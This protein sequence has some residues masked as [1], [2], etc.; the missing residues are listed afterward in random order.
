[1]WPA[2]T[3]I[4][5]LWSS[6]QSKN[7]T[8]N[9]PTEET[10]PEDL[11]PLVHLLFFTQL[12][13]SA[14]LCLWNYSCQRSYWSP[15]CQIHYHF[16]VLTLWLPWSTCYS[17]P[18]L[19]TAKLSPLDHYGITF[20]PHRSL[21]PSLSLALLLPL[22]NSERVGIPIAPFSIYNLWFDNSI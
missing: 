1:M 21:L 7:K 19:P 9:Q 6:P 22:P 3:T 5:F 4:L 8:R 16:Y 2:G 11:S 10:K 20:L 14:S 17:W 13:H 12:S 15:C 18:F